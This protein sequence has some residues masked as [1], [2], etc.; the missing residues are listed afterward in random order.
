L[1]HKS[2]EELYKALSAASPDAFVPG[3]DGDFLPDQPRQLYAKAKL[4]D[5][6]FLVGSNAEEGNLYLGQFSDVKDE[7]TYHVTMERL[8][9]NIP[10]KELCEVYP[11]DRFAHAAHPYQ[12]ALGYVLGDGNFVCPTLDTATRAREAGANVYLYNFDGPFAQ[13]VGDAEHGAEL[14][15]L[16]GTQRSPDETELALSHNV[17]RLWTNFVAHG[18]PNDDTDP[19]WLPLGSKTPWRMN[20][21]CELSLLKQ[22]RDAECSLWRRYYDQVFGAQP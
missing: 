17:Q 18:D 5:T 10:L 14:P 11:H 16:F 4:G 12:V 7:D 9:P 8:F 21:G 6:G 15:Y 20:L 22:F 13:D 19:Y 2:A 1:Q 3:V